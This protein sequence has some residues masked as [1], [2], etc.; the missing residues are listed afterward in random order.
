[1]HS[2]QLARRAAKAGPYR[3]IEGMLIYT[4]DCVEHYERSALR[5]GDHTTRRSDLGGWLPQLDDPATL[6]CLLYLL[7]E[8]RKDRGI[9]VGAGCE[10]WFAVSGEITEGPWQGAQNVMV[11]GCASEA[12]AIVEALEG[13]SA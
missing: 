3:L 5:V 12:H 4:T 2:D 13:C 9:S 6:G 10:G 7:R 11:A 1:M 8:A